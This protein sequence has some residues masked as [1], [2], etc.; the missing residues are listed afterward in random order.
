MIAIAAGSQ[1][2]AAVE[3][4][5]QHATR[6]FWVKVVG[7]AAVRMIDIMHLSKLWHCAMANKLE[8][9]GRDGGTYHFWL[10]AVISQQCD[11]IVLTR[12][13]SIMPGMRCQYSKY[14]MEG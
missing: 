2:N 14:L 3:N 10:R 9:L 8:T 7:K 13:L 6:S 1:N 4:L 5:E 12:Y 11:I